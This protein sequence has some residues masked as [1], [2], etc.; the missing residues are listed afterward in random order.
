M[1]ILDLR[2]NEKGMGLLSILLVLMII[3]FVYYFATAGDKKSSGESS[4]YL[5]QTAADAANSKN[6][7]ENTKFILDKAV[8]VRGDLAE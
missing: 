7:L 1:K 5:N 8:K 3:G 4:S 2:N 6:V